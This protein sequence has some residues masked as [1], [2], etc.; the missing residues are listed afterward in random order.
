MS[1]PIIIVNGEALKLLH[2]IQKGINTLMA[3]TQKETDAV[4]ALS[5]DIDAAFTA[6]T[7]N[8]KA[9]QDQIDAL[10]AAGTADAATIAALQAVVDSNESDVLNALGGLDTHVKTLGGATP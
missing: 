2:S 9:L 4:N 3:L 7:T 8:N 10:K 5:A 1:Q 6:A